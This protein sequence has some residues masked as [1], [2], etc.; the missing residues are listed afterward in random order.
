[1]APRA[2]RPRARQGPGG[3]L[4]AAP[5]PRC[6]CAH[7][8]RAVALGG[9]DARRAETWLLS[10]AELAGSAPGVLLMRVLRNAACACALDAGVSTLTKN[11][12]HARSDVPSCPFLGHRRRI[13]GPLLSRSPR[14]WSNTG[15]RRSESACFGPTSTSWGRRRPKLTRDGQDEP[16]FGQRRCDSGRL[17]DVA[18]MWSEC[19]PFG[20]PCGIL[21]PAVIAY[22]QHCSEIC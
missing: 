2:P 5:R 17:V 20:T 12:G 14:N 1:M 8:G 16:C 18:Q 10:S 7:V 6:S 15:R 22:C 9:I 11:L 21:G 13:A 19:G 3:G 4:F